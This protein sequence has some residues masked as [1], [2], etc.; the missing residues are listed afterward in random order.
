MV[1]I[2]IE[3]GRV[4]GVKRD[5]YEVLGVDRDSAPDQVK[6][7][8]RRLAHKYHPDRN[9]DAGAE[10]KFKE[11]AEAYEVLADPAKRQRYDQFG[12]AG[13]SGAGVHDFSHMR[14]DD[15]FSMFSDIFDGA[16]GGGRRRRGRGADLQTEVELTIAGSVGCRAVDRVLPAG[17][18]CGL[19][20]PEPRIRCARQRSRPDLRGRPPRRRRARP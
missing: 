1:R 16:F 14:A 12:H 11:A 7:A 18:L 8:Y 10:G 3:D 17:L 19:R 4:A 15:I 20:R 5:Y 6:K 2:A 13:L 9:S